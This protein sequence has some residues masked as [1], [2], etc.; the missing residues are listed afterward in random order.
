[1]EQDMHLTAMTRDGSPK[2]G[3]AEELRIAEI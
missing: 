3:F 2:D 1:M